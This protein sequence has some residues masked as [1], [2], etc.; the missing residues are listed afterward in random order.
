MDRQ[1]HFQSVG[2]SRL[3]AA[4]SQQYEHFAGKQIDL[5]ACRVNIESD[6]LFLVLRRGMP[7]LGKLLYLRIEIFNEPTDRK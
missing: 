4:I 3:F 6:L 5:V 2:R 7:R 1:S